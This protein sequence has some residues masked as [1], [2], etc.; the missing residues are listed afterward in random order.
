MKLGPD[1]LLAIMAALQKGLLEEVDISDELRKI[2]VEIDPASDDGMWSQADV[3][4]YRVLRVK[5][6]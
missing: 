4:D 1:V 3:E 6:S 5:Q 2:E